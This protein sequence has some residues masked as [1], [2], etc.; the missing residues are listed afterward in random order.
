MKTGNFDVVFEIDEALINKGL[1]ALFYSGFIYK[2]KTW[3]PSTGKLPDSI[4]DIVKVKYELRLK[5]EP[6]IDLITDTKIRLLVSTEAYLTLFDGYELEFDVN[7]GVE[8]TVAY[9]KAANKVILD[10]TELHLSSFV[11]DNK[12]NVPE[13]PFAALNEILRQVVVENLTQKWEIFDMK[14]PLLLAKLPKMPDGEENRVPV[15]F[16]GLKTFDKKI[17]A[18]C[19]NVLGYSGG[20][21]GS[22][23]NFIGGNNYA[24][25]ITENAIHRVFDFWWDRTTFPKSNSKDKTYDVPMV[26]DFVDVIADV[27]GISV[28]LASAGF[29][30][31]DFAVENIWIEYGATITLLKPNF[32][33]KD[34][35]K[36]EIKD[37]YVKAS[38]YAKA[39]ATI[40]VSVEVDTSGL[41]PDWMTPWQDDVELSK[42]TSVVELFSLSLPDVSVKTNAQGTVVI[43]DE[44]E[45][46]GKIDALDIDVDLG[47]E[48]YTHLPKDL[49]D[50]VIKSHLKDL[51]LEKLDK[52]LVFPA[53][54]VKNIPKTD[55]SVVVD[56]NLM[57]VDDDE[58]CVGANIDVKELQPR[59]QPVPRYIANKNPE[60]R[61]VH[62][63]DCLSVQRMN[64]ANK[65]GYYV[66]YD[67]LKDGYDGCK[68]CIPEYHTK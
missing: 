26:D 64:E 20:N 18:C 58:L 57:D 45:V 10:L 41:I 46:E 23:T 34:G 28:K 67:A 63:N 2:K 54:V 25:G 44:N 61:E 30:E 16:G 33:L 47:D 43:N 32:D 60:S 55:F 22:V 29:M 35:N 13:K 53:I 5:G 7:F 24:V 48:W 27:A 37:T 40:S 42:Q 6:L 14:T 8:G 51:I 38:L 52:L 66:L 36:L 1:A 49:I 4:K 39:K 62:R 56:V 17:F 9:D 3:V 59:V 15:T 50:G 19:F 65:V 12:C 21:I 68:K 31:P 11:V